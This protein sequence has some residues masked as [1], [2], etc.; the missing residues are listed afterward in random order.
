M[1]AAYL[2]RCGC[3]DVHA[4]EVAARVTEGQGQWQ[5]SWDVYPHADPAL[6][7]EAVA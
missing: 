3:G 7:P 6:A 5:A 4:F 2:P 1:S